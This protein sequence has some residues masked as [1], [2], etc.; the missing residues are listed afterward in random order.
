MIDPLS[1]IPLDYLTLS[2]P[3]FPFD[4]PE[5]IRKPKIFWCF[6]GDQ[7][8][9]LGRKGLKFRKMLHNMVA[10]LFNKLS[11]DSVACVTWSSVICNSIVFIP[12]SLESILFGSLLVVFCDNSIFGICCYRYAIN[13]FHLVLYKPLIFSSNFCK[14]LLKLEPDFSRARGISR[15]PHYLKLNFLWH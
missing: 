12:A 9:T 13:H 15:S 8:G 3:M 2:F 5:N 11:W 4:H 10:A 6:Q 1:I 14:L 7:K